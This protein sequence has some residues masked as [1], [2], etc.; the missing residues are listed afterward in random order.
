MNEF[1]RVVD[2]RYLIFQIWFNLLFIF[3]WYFSIDGLAFWDD[4]TYLNFANQ[5]NY[6]VFEITKNH[7]TSRVGVIYPVAW[8]IR[9]LEINA[10]TVALY[11]L[12]CA[13]VSLNLLMWYGK[14]TNIWVG[15]LGGFFV[16]CDYH[17]LHFS[18]HLFPE[19]PMTV[20]VLIALL[21]YDLVNRKEGDHR[22]LALLTA[23]ALFVAYLI[24]TTVFLLIPLFLYLFFNDRLRRRKHSS[25][26]NITI[27]CLLFF[28]VLNLFHY[29]EVK[30]DAFYRFNN[31]AEN[32]EAS[33]KTFFDKPWTET[34]KRLTYLPFLGFLRGGFFIPLM[35]AI[36]AI[37]SIK[38]TYWRLNDASQIWV[39]SSFMILI[40]WWF[41]STNWKYYSPM[42]AETRHITFVIPLLILA[43]L[44]WWTRTSFFQYVVRKPSILLISLTLLVI[45][46]YKMSIADSR[47]FRELEQ[48]F[49]DE[50]IQRDQENEVVQTVYTDGLISYGFPYFYS[51]R[52]TNLSYKW[53]AEAQ[54]DRA[55]LGDFLL[56]NPAYMNPRYNDFQKL[57]SLKAFI[58]SRD[59]RLSCVDRGQVQLC[60][61]VK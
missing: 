54:F 61:I 4:F 26:W 13:M 38:K 35:L 32:H 59:W 43:G 10:Y 27:I 20:C 7:F 37:V 36:P 56:I 29:Y 21:S 47:N 49:T 40:S 44:Q 18:T 17:F 24:K 31:I 25:Y 11:P 48:V 45:P 53:W 52:Q 23:T 2:K 14:R 46:T 41:M 34:L 57:E 8:V 30:G 15:L 6:D 3:F 19:M 60:E 22:F 55:K 16:I 50:I 9:W 5:V 39:I 58:S 42:P 28:F 51:F 33:V 1:E 12:I